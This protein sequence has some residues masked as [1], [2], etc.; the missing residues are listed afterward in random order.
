MSAP[1][2]F[3]RDSQRL[4]RAA[5]RT[6]WL[7][8]IHAVLVLGSYYVLSAAPGV[9]SSDEEFADFYGGSTDRSILL[10]AGFYLLPFAGIAFMWFIIA[11]RMWIRRASAAL[12]DELY[13]GGQ[14]VSGIVFL[15]LLLIG[16][17]A[18]S[19]LAVSAEPA[20][21]GLDPPMARQFTELGWALIVVFAMRMAAVFIITTSILGRRHRF[22][23]SWF[24]IAGYVIGA[25]LLLSATVST[26]LV[27]VLL[28][29]MLGI[30][31]FLLLHARSA[32][33]EAS[34]IRNEMPPPE[35][36][37]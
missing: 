27:L 24:V 9:S 13:S 22:L 16:A 31:V 15:T 32:P 18:I 2:E 20:G 8:I 29:W 10:I 21:A 6:G 26:L 37:G 3:S 28:I 35:G 4:R 11:L 25:I 19:V 17:G 23:P 36:T 33:E 1:A 34:S 12:R 30:G 14:L 7:A 5:S